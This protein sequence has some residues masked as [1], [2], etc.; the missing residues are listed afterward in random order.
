MDNR[1]L[2]FWHNQQIASKDYFWRQ[3]CMHSYC[4]RLSVFHSISNIELRN[5]DLYQTV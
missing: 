2:I 4:S 3:C 1:K 5:D